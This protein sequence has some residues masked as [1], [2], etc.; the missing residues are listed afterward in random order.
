MGT[1]VLIK[2]TWY[3]G[4][5]REVMADAISR[6]DAAERE[7]AWALARRRRLGP[8]RPAE[9]ASSRQ[10]DL[11]A[12]ARA[13]FGFG[14]ARSVIDGDPPADGDAPVKG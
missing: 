12:M 11:A 9:R 8:F 1:P 4:V 14:L 7:A 3:K 13:G 6:D 2:G 5:S 10:R